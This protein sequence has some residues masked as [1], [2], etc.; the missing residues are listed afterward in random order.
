M[1]MRVRSDLCVSADGGAAV[2]AFCL[3][4]EY[5][6]GSSPA[7]LL[8][9]RGFSTSILPFSAVLATGSLKSRETSL[10]WRVN[11]PCVDAQ[12]SSAC[13]F[14]RIFAVKGRWMPLSSGKCFR[15]CWNAIIF[16][17]YFGDTCCKPLWLRWW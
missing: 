15:Q 4:V 11:Q 5:D 12:S 16:V 6:V 7:G 8:A 2:M 10:S 9:P 17:G 1:L 13:A 3:M 14:L